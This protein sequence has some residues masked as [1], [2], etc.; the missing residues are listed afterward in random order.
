MNKV[1]YF[2]RFYGLHC[3][4]GSSVS[5]FPCCCC[6]FL[7]LRFHREMFLFVVDDNIR[8]ERQFHDIPVVHWCVV[9]HEWHQ[10]LYSLECELVLLFT[11]FCHVFLLLESDI[12]C[13]GTIKNGKPRWLPMIF[14]IFLTIMGD[15]K[16]AYPRARLFVF[17]FSFPAISGRGLPVTNPPIRSNRFR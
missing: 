15:L 5:C 11:D 2:F 16:I 7:S 10:L 14:Y 13:K 17:F 6:P 12:P 8:H 9:V 3:D 4:G 1:C